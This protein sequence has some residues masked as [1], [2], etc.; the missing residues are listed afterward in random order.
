MT[1]RNLFLEMTIT[2]ILTQFI[3]DTLF[4]L[5]FSCILSVFAWMMQITT[6]TWKLVKN[7]WHAP[8]HHFLYP[9][10][11]TAVITSHIIMC[12]FEWISIKGLPCVWEIESID[13]K[14]ESSILEAFVK[15]L[16]THPLITRYTISS[17]ISISIISLQNFSFINSTIVKL[18]NRWY[19][20]II[21]VQCEK[22]MIIIKQLSVHS[23]LLFIIFL[24]ES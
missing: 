14:W 7:H 11:S 17:F 23:C 10:S 4:S 21:S 8:L 13:K 16:G 6:N 15:L 1:N 18:F 24:F 9:F 19:S 3:Y 22:T 12:P 2:R 5:L 20:Y